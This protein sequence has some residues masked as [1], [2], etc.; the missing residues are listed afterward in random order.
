M[1]IR[2]MEQPFQPAE[3]R[4]RPVLRRGTG[5]RVTPVVSGSWTVE[6]ASGE[7]PARDRD[8]PA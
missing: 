4:R 5:A 3:H 2:H 7:D 1:G 6:L 8:V